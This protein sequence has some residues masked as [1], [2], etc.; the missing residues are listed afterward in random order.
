MTIRRDGEK[1]YLYI[2]NTWRL[3]GTLSNNV[4]TIHQSDNDTQNFFTFN[5]NL[6]QEERL[7]D[8]IEI[9]VNDKKKYAVPRVQ[10]IGKG[11]IKEE[12]QFE[13]VIVFTEE[14]IKSVNQ[15]GYDNDQR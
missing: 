8:W 11:T 5:F 9:Y 3:I 15:F 4:L 10:L 13:K 7:F 12:D 2:S 6:L 14:E 1:L